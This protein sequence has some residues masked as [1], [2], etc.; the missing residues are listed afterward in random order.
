VQS[1]VIGPEANF[2]TIRARWESYLDIE[3]SAS[4]MVGARAAPEYD[5]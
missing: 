5:S 4:P 2:N 3:R 1:G